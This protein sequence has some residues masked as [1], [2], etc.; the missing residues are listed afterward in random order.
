VVAAQVADRDARINVIVDHEMGHVLYDY[1]LSAEG[2]E[3]TINEL[4]IALA[5]HLSA[6][7]DLRGKDSI[8]EYGNAHPREH[9][10]EA[11]AQYRLNPSKLSEGNRK[12]IE[13]AL[14][15]V[16]AARLTESANLHSS[17]DAGIVAVAD[18]F[19]N[20]PTYFYSDGTTHHF[21]L[22][23]DLAEAFDPNQPRDEHG[24]FSGGADHGQVEIEQLRGKGDELHKFFT[25]TSTLV[26]TK[27]LHI[28]KDEVRDDPKYRAGLK[29]Y[30]VKTAAARMGQSYNGQ[31]DKREPITVTK[32][33]DG[34][35][36]V[37]DGNATAKAAIG[38]GWSHI[39]VRI[40]G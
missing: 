7:S 1:W 35:Y 32:L 15:K 37:E 23:D 26:P 25:D 5:Q 10:A 20:G 24:K 16:K 22:N 13:T 34:R 39:P 27:L 19:E 29:P 30:P 2:L 12:M 9:F 17:D 21:P 33:P 40:N 36:H 31:A 6:V 28:T 18:D 4:P 8:S 14:E 11:Y 38:A 3:V